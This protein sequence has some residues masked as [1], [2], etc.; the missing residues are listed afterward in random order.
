MWDR[1]IFLLPGF[2]IIMIIGKVK[3]CRSLLFVLSILAGLWD[4]NTVSAHPVPMTGSDTTWQWYC[5]GQLLPG[6]INRTVRGA[7]AAGT[8]QYKRVA[9]VDAEVVGIFTVTLTIPGGIVTG[10][11]L[12]KTALSLTVGSKETLVATVV[13]PNAPDKTVTWSSSAPGVATVSSSGE[14]IAIAAGTATITATSTDGGKAATCEVV[15]ESS[16]IAVTGVSLSKTT[17]SLTVGEKDVLVATVIPENASDKAVTWSS[18]NPYVA[19][20]SETGEVTANYASRAT[21]TVTTA[22]GGK[23]ASCGV[24][25]KASVVAVTGVTLNKTALPLAVGDKET[26]VAS[27]V[28]SNASNKAVSWS[29]SEPAVATVSSG[30]E[31]TAVSAGSA[32]I[33]ATTADGGK[34]AVCAVTVAVPGIGVSGVTLNKTVLPLTVGNKETLIV[35]VAPEN[36]SNKAVS[37]SSGNS[38]IAAV[39]SGG[40]VTAITAGTAIITSTTADGGKTATCVVTVAT[41]TG[42]NIGYYYYNDGTYSSSRNT[43]KLCVG[44]V[45]WVDPLNPAKGKIISLDEPEAGWNGGSNYPGSL[46]WGMEKIVTHATSEGDGAMNTA[47][48]KNLGTYSKTTY[49]AA[50]WCMDKGSGWYLPAKEELMAL[51]GVVTFINPILGAYPLAGNAYYWSSSEHNDQASWIILLTGSSTLSSKLSTGR[52]RAVRAF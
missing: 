18:S 17:L 11:V 1:G 36:A 38:D 31:V 41:T 26:L 39:S 43:S 52:I 13:P 21:I 6:E 49:P 5:N 50:A 46:E 33:T 35:T 22:D 44:V 14:I 19:K 27:V 9:T 42:P 47:T 51:C 24:T 3:M 34:T 25:V 10:V 45:F 48:I 2:V 40:E 20:V 16:V 28:P 8:Y 37:W 30:G 23:T 7:G 32:T 29:S 4:V 12:N 15:V